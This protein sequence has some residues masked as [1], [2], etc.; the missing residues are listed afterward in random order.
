MAIHPLIVRGAR[1][2]WRW[3]WLRL[4]GGLGPADQEGHYRRPNSTPM[5]TL[6]LEK[7]ALEARTS[8][9]KPHLIVGRSCPWAH[10]VWLVFQLRGLSSSINLLKAEASHDEGRWRLEPTWLGCKS[11]LDLYKRCGAPPSYRATVPVLVDPGASPSDQPRLLGND[12]TPLSA[13]LCSWPA[14]ETALNLA[15]RDLKPA[16]ESWQELIQ[17]S[18]NDGV[19]RC[20]FARNQRAF[21]QASQ[22]LFSALE[23]VEE[24]LQAKG[25]WLCG[26]QITLADVRL[27]PTL[28]RWELVYAS[29]F[30][31]SAK[32]LWMFPALW[33]WRQRFF[34]LPGVRE[35]CDSKGW[36]Q[37][38]FGALF[39]LNPSGIV[40]DSP[41]LSRLI[42]AGVAQPE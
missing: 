17:P 15:P 34:V 39:P 16:I 42:G 29:L 40:P 35:S 19:Y 28:I 7:K 32:P 38:Y 26:E 11:L 8:T 23:Q 30:G 6:V 4:M 33:S 3:Q 9:T 25:P 12:S 27:F 20:G 21:D 14:E 13:A 5:Q 1:E 18:I 2:G 22:A 10:R 36:T 24:S 31:C 41:D 37:D